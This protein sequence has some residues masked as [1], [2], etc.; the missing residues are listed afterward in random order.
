L[1][2]A[3][4]SLGSIPAEQL[5]AGYGIAYQQYLWVLINLYKQNLNSTQ[6]CR[7]VLYK[8]LQEYLKFK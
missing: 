3:V 4:G 1:L 8:L 6:G 5:A 2:Q 7:D